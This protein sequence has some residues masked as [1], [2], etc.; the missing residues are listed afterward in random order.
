MLTF[1]DCKIFNASTVFDFAVELQFLMAPVFIANLALRTIA[2]N[3]AVS[4]SGLAI[5]VLIFIV[6]KFRFVNLVLYPINKKTRITKKLPG[7]VSCDFFIPYK[8]YPTA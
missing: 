2:N 3:S 8:R 6:I 4:I 7:F 1:R 5:K